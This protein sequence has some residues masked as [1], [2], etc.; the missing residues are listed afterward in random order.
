MQTPILETE[1]LRLRAHELSDFDASF[2]MWADPEVRRFIGGAPST[3]E[4]S[5][6][7]LLRYIGHWQAMGFGFWVAE[8]KS[9]GRFVGEIGFMDF[10][11]DMTPGF[12]DEPEQGWALASWC[13]GMGFATE[14]VRASL[15]WGE[16]NLKADPVCMINPGNSASI[17]VAAK[18]G[19]ERYAE[20]NY[21]G[22]EV[23]LYRRARPTT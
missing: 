13:H 22:S 8:Q 15:K 1:R 9:D 10:K 23:G 5:W 20:G 16:A 2:A 4:E 21:K 19:Y 17:N 7:R 11:R 6:G 3:R 14:A 12:G 18:A